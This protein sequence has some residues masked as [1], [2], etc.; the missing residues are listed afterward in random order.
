MDKREKALREDWLPRLETATAVLEQELGL[1]SGAIE[2]GKQHAAKAVAAYNA[3]VSGAASVAQSLA[4][5]LR[6][7][8]D[9]KSERWQDGDA[10]QEALEE[11]ER[12]EELYDALNGV[13]PPVLPRL[14]ID[15]DVDAVDKLKEALR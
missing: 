3:V 5:D 9:E 8:W 10:G 4:E 6:E 7:T 12:W 11:V 14:E 15:G 1:A 2:A 13:E